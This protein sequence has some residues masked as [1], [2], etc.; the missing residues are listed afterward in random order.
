MTEMESVSDV[1]SE[2][3]GLITCKSSHMLR[4]PRLP[5]RLPWHASASL[6]ETF[7][8]RLPERLLDGK[9]HVEGQPHLHIHQTSPRYSL[10]FTATASRYNRFEA[11]L[12]HYMRALLRLALPSSFHPASPLACL[13]LH[14]FKYITMRETR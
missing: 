7:G 10:V 4:R 13:S 1:L 8:F 11:T 14:A 5:Y 6:G 9:A 12:Q 3:A 2:E